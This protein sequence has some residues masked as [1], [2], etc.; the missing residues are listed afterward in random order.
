MGALELAVLVGG[1]IG[2]GLLLVAE[3]LPL[4]TVRSSA[5][6]GVIDTVSTGSHDSFALVPVALLAAVLAY[7]IWR[8]RSRLA[9]L[10][11]AMLGVLVLL[12]A[13]LGDLPDAQATGLVGSPATHLAIAS[14]SPGSGLYVETLGA[15]VLLIT[16]AGGLLLVAPEPGVGGGAEQSADRTRSAS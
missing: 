15:F 5:T 2:A 6:R 11:T 4:L 1:A 9:L 16:A 10:A 13:L 3:F 8:T 14:S 12:I 7:G